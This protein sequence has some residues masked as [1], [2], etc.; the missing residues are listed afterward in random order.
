MVSRQKHAVVVGGGI[1]GL[2]TSVGLL[3][4]GWR[5]S[6]LE[7]S[8]QLRDG[9]GAILLWPNALFALRRL[10]LEDEVMA[11]GTPVETMDFETAAGKR[12]W[13]LPCGALGRKL[14][15]SVIMVERGAL[16]RVLAAAA[17]D[18]QFD[19]RVGHV[20]EGGHPAV[21]M[22]DGAHVHGDVVLAADGIH[23][24]AAEA[25]SSNGYEPRRIGQVAWI[26]TID[27]EHER[28]GSNRTIALAG[29]GARF[30][31][32]PLRGHRV[33]WYA[34]VTDGVLATDGRSDDEDRVKTLRRLFNGWA[35][36]IEDLLD[37]SDSSEVHRIEI[38]DRPTGLRWRKHGVAFLGDAAHP[39][40]P[41]LG[42][43]ACQALEDAACMVR[44]LSFAPDVQN[45]LAGWERERR[46]RAERFVRVSR[47]A[48]LGSMVE[49][50][51]EAELRDL[52]SRQLLPVAGPLGLEAL[53]QPAL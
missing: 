21:V 40:C 10:G 7:R 29:R 37:Q 25:W 28:L 52:V 36:P 43:G 32:S 8:A 46:P 39:M 17:G 45:A 24:A 14:D 44:W 23:S 31:A 53:T 3:R 41:D 47:L 51:V 26:A 12:L 27:A 38:L 9:G 35:S 6:T 30:A 33:Y 2:A 42:Q 1:A 22:T 4:E 13:S 48:A 50:P 15:S 18:V 11:I 5:V 16:I 20:E 49:H 19:A 34:T